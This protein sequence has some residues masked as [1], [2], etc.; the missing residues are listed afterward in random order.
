ML[1]IVGGVTVRGTSD[2]GICVGVVVGIAKE[3]GSSLGL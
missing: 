3:G 2:V 1:P